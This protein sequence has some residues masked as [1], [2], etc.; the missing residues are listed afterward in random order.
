MP[1]EVAALRLLEL[2]GEVAARI[3]EI[4]TRRGRFLETFVEKNLELL[5][6]LDTAGNTGDKLD[7]TLL[8]IKALSKLAPL[9]K[10]GSLKKQ[11]RVVLPSTAA[12]RYDSILKEYWNAIVSQEKSRDAKKSRVEILVGERAQSLFRE[13]EA[14]F[15]RLEKSGA[16]LFYY[17]FD[18]IELSREQETEIRTLLDEFVDETKGNATPQQEGAMFFKVLSRLN[19]KQQTAVMKKVQGVPA[20]KE[21]P[22]PKKMEATPESDEKKMR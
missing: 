21:K 10:D 11:I 6:E 14:A 22:A 3:D 20:Q 9:T 1:P 15:K 4:V 12:E 13:V 19:V 16:L 2:P 18:K 5:S 17:F 8:G 7:Q